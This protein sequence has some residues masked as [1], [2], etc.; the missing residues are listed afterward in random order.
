MLAS[1]LWDLDAPSGALPLT[2]KRTDQEY[3][4]DT[5]FHP[6]GSWLITANWRDLGFCPLS[7]HYPWVLDHRGRVSN[8]RLHWMASGF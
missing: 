2:M 3:V 5:A 6:A 8:R 7:H 4:N 1:Q